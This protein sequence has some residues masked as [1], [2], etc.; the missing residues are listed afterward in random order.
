MSIAQTRSPITVWDRVVCAIDGAP[1]SVE[2]ARVAARLMPTSGRLALCTVVSPDGAETVTNQVRTREAADALSRAQA[3]VQPFHDAELQLRE[4]S[5]IGRLADELLAERATLVTVGGQATG[6]AALGRVASAML[7]DAPC[8]V[9][10]AHTADA[11]DG[12]VVVGFDGS[13]GA[14]RALAVG[15]ELCERLSLKLRVLVATGDAHLLGLE[16]SRAELGS[17]IDVT[18]DPR[19]AVEALTDTSRAAG[20]L[21]LGSRHLPVALALSSVSEQAARRATCPVLVVR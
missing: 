21:L 7:H 14:R 17:D 15:H 2:A 10:V 12:E 19:T 16:W 6:G 4:G 3:D 9:L 1:L 8:S 13:G 18:E 5:P 11:A 20:L